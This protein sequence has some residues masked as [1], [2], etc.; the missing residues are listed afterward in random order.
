MLGFLLIGIAALA[1][2]QGFGL[3]DNDD[4]EDTE[5]VIGELD[6]SGAM[7]L[8]DA[9]AVDLLRDDVLTTEG[10]LEP[11]AEEAALEQSY[12]DYDFDN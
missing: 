7:S 10:F 6:T 2:T 4:I 8:L 5:E 9:G 1:L 3:L 12:G 11:L